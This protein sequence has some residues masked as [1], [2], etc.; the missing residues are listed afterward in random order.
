MRDAFYGHYPLTADEQEHLRSHAVIVMDTNALLNLYRYSPLARA[1]FHDALVEVADRL[2]M[3]Y[4]VGLEFHAQRVSRI[5]EQLGIEKAFSKALDEIANSVDGKLGKFKKNAFIAVDGLVA[6][7]VGAVNEVREELRSARAE[8]HG[9]Y[10]VSVNDDP[11]LLQLATLY[12]GK[13]GVAY[14]DADLTEIYKDADSRYENRIPP[15]YEDRSK[16]G[17]EKYGDFVI[18]RQ[19]LDYAKVE[20][21]D[22]IFVTD[23]GK[24]DWWLIVKDDAIGK[25]VLGPRVELRREF[26]EIA[27]GSFFIYSP[28]KFLEV[29]SATDDE[30]ASEAVVEIR[31]ASNEARKLEAE[32]ARKEQLL[33]RI[34]E[35]EVE[36]LEVQNQLDFAHDRLREI[37]KILDEHEVM[38]RR[39]VHLESEYEE[40]RE[41][42]QEISSRLENFHHRLSDD[43]LDPAVVTSLR[44]Q[45]SVAKSDYFAAQHHAE[46]VYRDLLHARDRIRNFDDASHDVVRVDYQAESKRIGHLSGRR[47]ALDAEIRNI[48][49]ILAVLG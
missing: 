29:Y 19:I 16:S 22:V 5:L 9:A 4:Q 31:E 2:W 7:I 1:K 24:E 13:V 27:G 15:G 6:K 18:W 23:D 39:Y 46:R 28:E 26:R 11:I 43:N 45:E 17:A 20:N 21:K 41:V 10:G 34:A 32:F 14:S 12:E 25:K 49:S 42:Q 40:A 8:R 48:S 36:R 37:T 38:K 33:D 47:E 44:A 35:L 3:P 30:V